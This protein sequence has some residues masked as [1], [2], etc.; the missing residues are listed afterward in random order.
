MKSIKSGK[1]RKQTDIYYSGNRRRVNQSTGNIDGN[2]FL[3]IL[4]ILLR[5]PIR[6]IQKKGFRPN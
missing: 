1:I 2:D 4:S 5:E 6:Q 3:P